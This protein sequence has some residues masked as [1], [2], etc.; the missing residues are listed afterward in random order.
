MKK[1]SSVGYLAI[2]A[3]MCAALLLG[4]CVLMPTSAPSAPA[5]TATTVPAVGMANPASVFCKE[6]GGQLKIEKDAK[7]NEIGICVF[8][9]GSQCE[10]WAFFRGECKPGKAA[11]S[12][13]ET[14]ITLPDGSQCLF[15][16][17]GAT[18]A[19]DGKRLNYT[20]G[21]TAAGEEIGLLG[22][23]EVKGTAWTVEKAI[24]GRNDKGFYVK[25]SQKVAMEISRVDL[26][27]GTQCLNAGRGA[28]L[29]F[30]GKRL[31][32][33]CQVAGAD[34]VGLIGD[35]SQKDYV[36][37]AERATI[38]R[39]EGTF[40]L[41]ESAIVPIKAVVGSAAASIPATGDLTEA[42]LR[43][44]KYDLPDLGVIELKDGKYEKKYGEGATQVNT[45]GY[46]T[47]AFG[48]L[49]KDGVNDAA[50]VLWWSGG[51][52]GT[53]V[54]LAAMLN[55]KG[56]PRQAAVIFLGDRANVESLAIKDGK[57]AVGLRERLA[58]T[59]VEKQFTL[60]GNKLVEAVA[61]TELTGTAWV[62][63]GLLLNDGTTK[64]PSDPTLYTLAFGA[65]GRA[66][67]KADCNMAN[68]AY[69]VDGKKLNFG[70]M[71][72]TLAACPPGSLY[73]EYLKRLGEVESYML[74]D[75]KL[76]LLLKMDSGNMKFAPRVASAEK[77]AANYKDATYQ[78]EGKQ[79]TL[80]N[81]LSEV[82]AAPGSATKIVT[83]YFGNEATGDLN[84]DG[85]P[86]VAF[87]LTQDP[88]GSGTFFYVVAAL[89]TETGY[90]GTNAVF[91]GDRIAPQPTNIKDGMIVVN[92]AERKAG[93]PFTT[94]PSIGVS[95]YLKVVDGKLTVVTPAGTASQ[96]GSVTG[97]VAYLPRIALAPNAVIEVSL[98]DVSKADAPATVI[99]S[100]TIQ[101]AG[102]QVPFSFELK[103]DPA[104]IDPKAIYA[105]RATINVDGKLAWTS[106]RSYP[107][108]T[109]G[110][111]NQVEV[112]VE[113]VSQP[114][115][116]ADLAKIK[117]DPKMY[118]CTNEPQRTMTDKQWQVYG[119]VEGSQPNQPGKP[120]QPVKVGLRIKF[121]EASDNYEATV[122]VVAPDSSTAAAKATVQADKWAEVIYPK[123]FTGAKPTTPGL[124]T[125]VWQIKGGFVA[126]YGFEVGDA[127]ATQSQPAA[128]YSEP[129]AYCAAVGTINAP[130]ARYTGPKMPDAVVQGMIKQGIVSAD[131][132]PQFQQNAVWRCMNN[133]VWFCH[134]GANLPCQEKADTSQAPTAAMSDFCK[135][136]PAAE[137]IPAAVTGRATVYSWKCQNGKPEVVKQLFK[138]DPQGYLADFWYALNAK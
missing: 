11:A 73:D 38:V 57:I 114:A 81:G 53:F 59:T 60:Q 43:N 65:D 16:G 121:G 138:V 39:K 45:A 101:A 87:L 5:P 125:I 137:N 92:Y 136:N 119:T 62:W 90:L 120:G 21:K 134:F 77:P 32:Y 76:I 72:T 19:F 47:S 126:C 8:A 104:R 3:L 20:C 95:K 41:G 85:K 124:Y 40:A 9:D 80:I 69:K 22:D 44:A 51:G 61:T 108:L 111:P 79:V 131:A 91:L 50:V 112:L 15:A 31:N 14:A 86:D 49:N 71:A 55:E 96:P 106:T 100:Q 132:P 27:D 58:T 12:A 75:G 29:A 36:W 123:D 10:E 63:Q 130:D 93:E 102:K 122:T 83:R 99:V 113:Q 110:A 97:T 133:S 64:T 84:G 103:F 98:V 54:H 128:T 70:L 94:A 78:I 30:N 135:A 2:A 18:L 109:K 28:T 4:S 66:S 6:K 107:V 25:E 116:D 89:R 7:G 17:R 67:I 35:F 34:Q 56:T 68:S 37:L 13:V 105:V 118:R 52:S 48:D 33:T 127:P 26:A 74:Q 23:P 88:G 82:A 24:I 117:Y 1:Q 115:A 42:L 46:L 129:V